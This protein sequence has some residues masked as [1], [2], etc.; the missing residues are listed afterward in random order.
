LQYD[1]SVKSPS[2]DYIDRSCDGIVIR[3]VGRHRGA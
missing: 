2:L 3:A 1:E